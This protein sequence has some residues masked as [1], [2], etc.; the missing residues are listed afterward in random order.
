MD[1]LYTNVKLTVE[2]FEDEDQARA[3]FVAEACP[4]GEKGFYVFFAQVKKA[5]KP[6]ATDPTSPPGK[7]KIHL[8]ADPEGYT[9]PHTNVAV[10]EDDIVQSTL[11]TLPDEFTVSYKA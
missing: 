1:R 4:E 6:A 5:S 7:I 3:K 10:F 8:M 9:V 11:T 2:N